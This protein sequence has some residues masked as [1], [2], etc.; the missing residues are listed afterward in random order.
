MDYLLKSTKRLKIIAFWSVSPVKEFSEL[1]FN[2]QKGKIIWKVGFISKCDHR[3]ICTV[4]A[5]LYY[6]W[7][8]RV[9]KVSRLD[10][11]ILAQQGY[12][13]ENKTFEKSVQVSDENFEK[14]TR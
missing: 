6:R 1:Q 3:V 2:V 5:K 8:Q 13:L 10:Y 4:Q 7:V 11:V 12:G 14:R 9:Q